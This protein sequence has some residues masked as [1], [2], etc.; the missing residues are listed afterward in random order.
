MNLHISVDF[1]VQMYRYTHRDVFPRTV[2]KKQR[3]GGSE[4]QRGSTRAESADR[5][6]KERESK[7]E[8]L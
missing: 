2:K 6:Q 5:T 3:K 7:E 8:I 1:S 4:R